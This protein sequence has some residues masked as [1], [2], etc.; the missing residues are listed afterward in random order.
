M[1]NNFFILL[2]LLFVS[3]FNTSF[4]QSDGGIKNLGATALTNSG[5]EFYFSLPANWEQTSASVRYIRLYITSGVKTEVSIYAGTSLKKKLYTVPY[6]IVTYDLSPEE[7]QIYK[8]NDRTPL[9]EDLKYEK[10]AIRILAKQAI[11]VYCI[12]RISFTSDGILA[13]PVNG[14]GKE[15]MVA[16]SPNFATAL[17]F[18]PAEVKITAPFDETSV[19]IT[20]PE[21]SSTVSHDA[22]DGSFT[23]ELDKGDVFAMMTK[24]PAI[25]ISGAII[26]SNKPISVIAGHMCTYLPTFQYPA[27]DYLVETMLPISAWGK[28]YHSV[29]YATRRK[30]DYYKIFAGEEN[31]TIFIN[32]KKNGIIT[33]KG[34]GNGTGFLE[35]LPPDI[36]PVEII[37]DKKIYVGQYN[38]SQTYDGVPSDPFYLMLTPLEQ[39]QK[40]FVF[41]TPAA[42]FPKN[43]INVV[44]DSVGFYDLELAPGGSNNFKKMTDLYDNTFQIFPTLINGRRYVGK[45]FLIQPGT[46]RVRCSQPFAAYIYGYG[47]FDSYGYPLSVATGDLSSLDKDAPVIDKVFDC[48]NVK[49]TVK[50][51]PDDQNVRSNLSS[52]DLDPE[53]FN[54]DLVVAD[55]VPGVSRTTTLEL[56]PIDK[57]QQAHAIIVMSDMAGNFSLDT[58]DYNPVDVDL[59]PKPI[60]FGETSNGQKITAKAVLKNL[61]FDELQ[62]KRLYLL[63]GN[64]GFKIV[65]P[66]GTFKLSPKGSGKDTVIVDLE[67]IGTKGGNY[68]DSILVEGL[69]A[70]KSLTLLKAFIGEPIIKVSDKNFGTHI[71]GTTNRDSIFITNIAQNGPQLVISGAT[72]PF[73]KNLDDVFSLPNGFPAFPLKLKP[74][75]TV[76][77]KVNFK[78]NEVKDYLDSVVFANNAPFNVLNDS[79]GILQGKGVQPQLIATDYDWRRRR[80]KTGWF[81]AKVYLVNLGTSNSQVNGVSSYVGDTS[82][83]RFTPASLAKLNNLNINPKDSIPL[84]VEFNPSV[85]GN[86]QM[87]INYNV[88]VGGTDVKS[89]LKGIGTYPFLATK[90]YDYGTLIVGEK[91]ENKRIVEFWIQG[92]QF[93]DS[94]TITKFDFTNTPEGD[95]RMANVPSLPITMKIGSNDTVRLEGYFNAK[96]GGIRLAQVKAV[97]RDNVDTTSHWSGVGIIDG[98]EGIGVAFPDLCAPAD[99]LLN[100]VLTNTGQTPITIDSLSLSGL[101]SEFSIVSPNPKLSFTIPVGGKQSVQIRF[102]PFTKTKQNGKLLVHYGSPKSPLQ[103]DVSGN[104]IEVAALISATLTGDFDKGTKGEIGGE[105]IVHVK[106]DQ[107]PTPKINLLGGYTV[108]FRYDPSEVDPQKAKIILGRMNGTNAKATVNPLSKDGELVI[109]VTGIGE[110]NDIEELIAVPFNVLLNENL[111]RNIEVSL[112]LAGLGCATINKVTPVIDIVPVCGLKSRLIEL[113]NKVY[114]LKQNVPNPFNPSTKIEY[115][116]G[117]DGNTEFVLRD[118]SGK[119][120]SRLLKTYQKPGSYEITLDV[121]NLPSG[122]YY[123]SIYSGAWSETKM[124]TIVK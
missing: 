52:I 112:L 41:C 85:K 99:S 86:R 12:N 44:C 19:V 13:L 30:G 6:D 21:G 10:K 118:M 20:L 36:N 104:T 8:R 46:Y 71:V 33:R 73:G 100:A 96:V 84:D 80:V 83:F 25:D 95:Y 74:K 39:Y 97:T 76:Y 40:Q 29:H 89:V 120:V 70:G 48:G 121:T 61:S 27:C 31:A 119:I 88:I 63:K 115:S 65:S 56:N 7:A 57:T 28:V 54:Y 93:F 14:L 108:I 107:L 3:Y 23:V 111:S 77:L 11:V 87:I 24:I 67:F 69:C 68:E 59:T 106:F 34:G 37:S 123:Y 124:M 101:G 47:E 35:Y 64:V 26:T 22:K 110:L 50:D 109:D 45:T 98:L 2:V 58:V 60:D 1:K 53:S 117:L 91:T 49:A 5:K 116:I 94:V 62:I 66:L 32:G 81:P 15:Y 55:F 78:P 51:Y 82:D 18:L 79:V 16:T 4:S 113:T 102:K 90:D 43:Y 75:D 38:N 9:P 72:G 17:Q 103:L 114:S 92:D 122:N 42:D 105:I